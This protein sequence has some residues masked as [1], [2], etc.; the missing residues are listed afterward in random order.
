[1]PG[2]DAVADKPPNPYAAIV[3]K[4]AH[5]QKLEKACFPTRQRA[6]CSSCRDPEASFIWHR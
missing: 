6:P 4:S 5:L 1:M 2:S 3:A